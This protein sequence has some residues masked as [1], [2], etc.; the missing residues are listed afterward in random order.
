[1]SIDIRT[2]RLLLRSFVAS[3]WR[4]LLEIAVD[5]AASPYAIYDHQFPTSETEVKRITGWFAT[6]SD[7]LAICEP[8]VDRVIGYIHLGSENPTER[9]LGYTLHSTYWGKGHAA[10]ACTAAID[11]AFSSPNVETIRSGTAKLNAPSAKLL[12]S[13]GFKETGDSPAS[14]ANDAQG[15]PIQFVGSSFVLTRDVWIERRRASS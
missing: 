8:S 10:E 7:F 6:R 5:K 15:K 3:D 2:K 14:F 11:H 9:D 13:L 4:D 1:M 12:R